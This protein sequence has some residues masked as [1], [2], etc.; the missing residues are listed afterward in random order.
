[1]DIKNDN[2]TT[3]LCVKDTDRRQYVG[4]ASAHPYQTKRPIVFSQALCLSRLCTFEKDFE[5]HMAEMKQWFAKRLSTG[6]N[7]FR[8]K[9]S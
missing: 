4:Y 5:R 9:Q 8:D 7:K 1:M 6:S 3:D 2:I